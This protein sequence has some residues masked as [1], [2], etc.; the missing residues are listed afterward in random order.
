MNDLNI[1]QINIVTTPGNSVRSNGKYIA[2][3][4][5][6]LY[7]LSKDLGLKGVVLRLLL[8]LLAT[9]DNTNRVN[10]DAQYIASLLKCDP[11]SVYRAI[12]QLTKMNIIC[13]D[14][15]LSTKAFRLSREIINPRMA[16]WGN[17]LKLK[18]DI[19]PELLNTQGESLI[20]GTV[21][22]LPSNFEHPNNEG[23]E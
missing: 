15:H 17:T 7:F 3:F 16:Y 18:K 8:Y 22:L 4:Q 9:V 23:D 1:T 13:H 12:R 6:A 14:E 19:L 5:D 21:M 11:S 20:P 2:V 10:V